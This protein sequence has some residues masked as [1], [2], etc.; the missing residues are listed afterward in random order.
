MELLILKICFCVFHVFIK[1]FV[2]DTVMSSGNTSKTL[3]SDTRK[4]TQAWAMTQHSRL[5]KVNF[6]FLSVFLLSDASLA[7]LPGPVLGGALDDAARETRQLQDGDQEHPPAPVQCLPSVVNRGLWS[8]WC[9]LS[10]LSLENW[11][12]YNGIADYIYRNKSIEWPVY[13]CLD[14]R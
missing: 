1:V 5:G 14:I 6:S 13:Y 12:I 4:T 10:S 11:I 3:G 9:H 7:E 2:L 8:D